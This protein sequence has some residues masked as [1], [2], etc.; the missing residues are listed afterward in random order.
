MRR[1]IRYHLKKTLTLLVFTIL[2]CGVSSGQSAK[3][4]IKEATKLNK[5]RRY[6]EAISKLDHALKLD[7]ANAKGFAQRG[8]AY[9]KLDSTEAAAADFAMATTLDRKNE[10]YFYEAGRLHNDLEKHK[11]AV[12]FLAY[13]LNLDKHHDLAYHEKIEAHMA[14]RD[15]YM[16]L[17]ESENAIKRD[18]TA[19]N[20]YYRALASDSLQD[21]QKASYNYGRAMKMDKTLE[22]A[23][24]GKGFALVHLKKLDQAEEVCEDLLRINPKNTGAY[25]CRSKVQFEKGHYNQAIVDLS[26]V[27]KF[28]PEN[29]VALLRRGKLYQELNQHANAIADYNK[30]LQLKEDY[31]QVYYLRGKSYEAL[32]NFERAIKDYETLRTLAPYDKQAAALHEKAVEKLFELHREADVP[33]FYFTQP[34]ERVLN[35][36]FVFEVNQG[37]TEVEI[38]GW[39]KDASKITSISINGDQIDVVKDT[40]NPEIC[41]KISVDGL[42]QLTVEVEDIYDNVL[43][44]TYEVVR[45][46]TDPPGIKII[47]P[48]ASDDGEIYLTSDEPILYIE[49]HIEDKSL[50]NLILID[51]VNASFNT[52]VLNPSFT[53]SI[54]ISNKD[55]ITL[56]AEDEYGNESTKTYT[57][58]REGAQLSEKNPMGKTWVVFIENS[59]YSSFASLDGPSKDVS[60]M[61][62]A[63]SNYEVHNVIVKKDMTKDNMERFFSIELRDMV[64]SNHVNSLLVWYA[65]HGKFINDVGYWIPTDS[66]R[67]DEFSYFN[68]NQLKAG[69]QGF[70]KFLTHTLVITDACESGPSFFQAMRGTDADRRCDDYTATAF[71][72]SQVFSSAGYELAS[73]NS[74]FTKTF[75]KSLQGNVNYCIPIDQ[76]VDNVNDAADRSNQQKAQFGTIQGMEDENGTF[77]F[78]KKSE[79]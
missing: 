31:Y 41:T 71:K 38:S 27:T 59:T 18:K 58:N 23:Y 62:G 32:N 20:F 22:E 9:D 66:E 69:L 61:R 6:E 56:R 50:L 24:V 46:E 79:H 3:K 45:T 30:V 37:K 78:V 36:A 43:V 68:I 65:G 75:A 39:T 13:A 73:D 25:F 12:V 15:F 42:S 54:D 47:A 63:L 55:Q 35:G 2:A 51:G 29:T 53:A 10:D 40:V 60:V 64:R 4:L 8:Y 1:T 34:L 14:L 49:G 57:L 26:T 28:E 48:V 52:Q 44:K 17:E 19:L 7:A 77:F 5:G 72:S 21:Y 70:S 16:A 74:Q 76:I 33:E 67:D 11:E